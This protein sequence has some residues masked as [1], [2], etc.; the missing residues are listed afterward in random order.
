MPDSGSDDPADS[1]GGSD[2]AVPDG[3]SVAEIDEERLYEIVHEAVEDAILGVV[4]TLLL[5]GIG[6]VFLVSGVTAVLGASSAASFGVGLTVFL[7]GLVVFVTT[8]GGV[9][10]VREWV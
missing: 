7:V 5:L 8:L 6:T 10:P 3:G 9:L 2:P 4:G 1:D